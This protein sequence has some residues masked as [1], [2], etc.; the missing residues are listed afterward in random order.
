MLATWWRYCFSVD[1]PGKS[2]LFDVTFINKLTIL[3]VMHKKRYEVDVIRGKSSSPYFNIPSKKGQVTIFIILGILLLL[4]FG[5]LLALKEEVIV[6][7]PEE[8]IP[9]AKGKVELF[10]AACMDQISEEALFKLG[11]QGG[12]I[13]VPPEIAEDASKHFRISPMNVIPFWAYGEATNIPSLEDLKKELDDYMEENLRECVYGLQAFQKTYDLVEKGGIEANTEIVESKV[14]FNARWNLE[15]RDKAGEVISE[16]LNHVTESDVNLKKVHETAKRVVEKEMQDL[17]LEDITQDLIAME[18]PNVPLMGFEVSC[19]EKKWKIQDVQK[20]LKDLLRVNIRELRVKGTDYVEFPD[21]LP[22]YQNHYIWDVGEDFLQPQ[23]S[24]SFMYENSFPF[25]F[26]VRPQSGSVLKS[27]QLGDKSDLLSFLCIQSWKFVYD[28]GYPVIVTVRDESTGYSF[29]FGLTVHLKNNYP[30]REEGFTQTETFT[31]DILTDDEFCAESDTP[32]TVFTFEL[33]ENPETGVHNREPLEDVQLSYTC[34]RSR[35]EMGGTEYDFSEMGHV[36]AYSTIFPAC[37]GGIMRGEKEGYKESWKRVVTKAG[38]EVE[39]DLIPIKSIPGTWV[40]V[41]KH[42]LLNEEEAGEEIGLSPEETAL[43]ELSYT[44]PNQ[45]ESFHNSQIVYSQ[46]IEQKLL[47][48]Q[49]LQ[50]L[51]K[52][53]FTYDVDINVMDGNKFIGGYKGKWT[54]HWNEL[55]GAQEIVFHVL[56]PADENDEEDWFDLLMELEQ[57]STLIPKPEAR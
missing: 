23:V 43:I 10:I 30:N 26:E 4:V 37:I 49:E 33:V 32:M 42:G 17:K 13:E 53:D 27:N 29:K 7:K 24:V 31:I 51:A 3:R 55:E 45:T 16:L 48:D 57:K 8:V 35:C 21:H 22:Y 54:P 46:Q 36:A 2:F 47:Q 1:G 38:K 15:V 18:H 28:V 11:L 6:V 50:F 12:Y 5:L 20:H 9:T 14:I 34:L 40:R 19:K 52:A 25:H 39:L 56:T 41:V 44:K